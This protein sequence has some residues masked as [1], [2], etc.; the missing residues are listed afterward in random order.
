MQRVPAVVETL[1]VG[2]ELAYLQIRSRT[3]SG[4][5]W[6]EPVVSTREV[7]N[8][9]GWWVSPQRGAARRAGRRSGPCQPS[10]PS[11][12]MMIN[13]SAESD[14]R[15]GMRH[16][17]IPFA[18]VV[19]QMS[20][21][22]LDRIRRHPACRPVE[23]A[24]SPIRIPALAGCDRSVS[25]RSHRQPC[26]PHR[27]VAHRSVHHDCDCVRAA[28]A[29]ATST[30]SGGPAHKT[31]P[32]NFQD[33][34]PPSGRAS[35]WCDRSSTTRP[36]G[37]PLLGTCSS[38]VIEPTWTPILSSFSTRCT[39]AARTA[40]SSYCG[41]SPP[42]PTVPRPTRRWQRYRVQG[43]G[44]ITIADS[45]PHPLTVPADEAYAH[46]RCAL[47]QLVERLLASSESPA[48]RRS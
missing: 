3:V 28:M 20:A 2:L 46:R 7:R 4:Y 11:S 9:V 18:Q 13:I 15:C 10:R 14:R 44:S 36:D 27:L 12:P 38:A 34:S 8:A 39:Y 33:C 5:I 48:P 45:A 1:G 22:R 17:S 43:S 6:R 47:F 29:P 37:H 31:W 35:D 21:S 24:S 41:L 32:P 30:V 23:V 25:W 42:P 40:S 26:I 19:R 16:P